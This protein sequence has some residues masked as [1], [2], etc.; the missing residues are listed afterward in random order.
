MCIEIREIA[1]RRGMRKFVRFYT[2]LY[3]NCEYSPISLHFDE[4]QTLSEKK[5]SAFKNCKAK[6]WMAFKDG[7]PVEKIA[8]YAAA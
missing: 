6:Y 2:N 3:K 8:K 4:L 1:T 7:N 5:N